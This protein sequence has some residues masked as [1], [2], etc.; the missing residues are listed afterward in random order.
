MQEENLL[1]CKDGSYASS[2]SQVNCQRSD[3]GRTFTDELLTERYIDGTAY[4]WLP[5]VFNRDNEDI[6]DVIRFLTDIS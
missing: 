1:L 5:N 4:H 2:E 3:F 6:Q